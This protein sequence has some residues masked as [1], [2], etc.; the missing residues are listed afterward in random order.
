MRSSV[1]FMRSFRPAALAVVGLLAVSAC[2]STS[3]A[4]QGGAAVTTSPS[5]VAT[6]PAKVL[7]FPPVSAREVARV[8]FFLAEGV[9]NQRNKVSRAPTKG[10]YVVRADCSA[11]APGATVTYQVYDAKPGAAGT[12]KAE[13]SGGVGCDDGKITVNSASPFFGDNI[14]IRLSDISDQVTRAYAV[15]V[16]EDE[17][18]VDVP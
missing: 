3:T 9:S 8:T 5:V 4:P 11:S 12:E 17:A 18:T 2:A 15:I 16:P 13:S 6:K 1:R 7:A 10:S 14:Q